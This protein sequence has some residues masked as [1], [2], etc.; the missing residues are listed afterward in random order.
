VESEFES[1]SIKHCRGVFVRG[2][3]RA[4]PAR[5]PFSTQSEPLAAFKLPPPSDP[6]T[7]TQRLS[8]FHDRAQMTTLGTG[9]HN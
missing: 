2:K 3:F 7:P 5:R 9:M 4:P 8:Q 1:P 6:P